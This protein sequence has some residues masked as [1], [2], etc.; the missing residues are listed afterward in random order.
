MNSES[1]KKTPM[2]IQYEKLK[3]EHMDCI[4]F[5][6]L[7]DFYEMF[8]KDAEIASEILGIVLT[9]RKNKSGSHKMCGVPFHSSENYINKLVEH[10]H[11]VA[12]AEQVSDPSQKGIV[13]RKVVNIVTPATNLSVKQS[14]AL[15]TIM[16]VEMLGNK[17]SMGFLIADINTLSLTKGRLWSL[18]ELDEVLDQHN[19]SEVVC[20]SDVSKEILQ[21]LN[22]KSILIKH[23]DKKSLERILLS[24]LENLNLEDQ[25][26]SLFAHIK[27]YI[28]MHLGQFVRSFQ[29]AVEYKSE[30]SFRLSYKTA[31]NLEV[32]Q[33]FDGSNKNSLFKHINFCQ[34]SMGSRKLMYNL[35]TPLSCKQAIE[36]R[37][38]KLQQFVDSNAGDK[39]TDILKEI[40]NIPRLVARIETHKATPADLVCLNSSLKNAIALANINEIKEIFGAKD[41]QGQL[42]D[43]L[44]KLDT[45]IE[46]DVKVILTKGYIFKEETT[47][48]LQGLRSIVENSHGLISNMLE[49]QKQATGIPNM[50]IKY[51]KV[52]GY[53]IE[54]SKGKTELVPEHYIRR[55]TLANAERYTTTDLQQF[56]QQV[57]S[58]EQDL[59]ALESEMF[60]ELLDFSKKYLSTI[61]ELSEYVAEIDLL[62]SHSECVGRMQFC[63]PEVTNENVFI[64]ENGFHPVIKNLLAYGEFIE[65][66][67][68]LDRKPFMVLTG[69]NMGG[70][71]TFLRQNAIILLLASIGCFVPASKA[72]LGVCDGIFTRV[73]ASDNLSKGQSTFMVEMEETAEILKKATPKSFVIIDELGR[74][75]SSLDGIAIASAVC[76][77]MNKQTKARTLFATH[78]FEIA[79]L[80]DQMKTAGNLCVSV[81]NGSDSKPVFLRKIIDGSIDR[82]YGVEVA[83]M[84]GLPDEI[85]VDSRE[86][87][88]CNEG[89]ENTGNGL[90]NKPALKTYDGKQLR[91]QRSLFANKEVAIRDQN[92]KHRGVA[93]YKLQSLLASIDLNSLTPIEAMVKLSEL[94]KFAKKNLK[95]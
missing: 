69:P 70:K 9:A 33:N 83:A 61:V 73:G 7:G 66:N 47:E 34:T 18:N 13:E 65:N 59:V 28:E 81:T 42:G 38:S 79:K 40:K 93:D 49:E 26:A 92:P 76:K 2:Q 51:N 36:Q 32:F 75:T 27:H 74:G 15:T 82:S 39:V 14:S 67:L 64:V 86:Y 84:A 46:T 50:K 71:S 31:V 44:E 52:F 94:Q 23:L 90:S 43:I 57:L 63:K 62:N 53:F 58:A 16:S 85:L 89:L 37:L 4:L 45:L 95:N 72:K 30:T 88:A 19:V 78:F 55:Q 41:Y 3:S 24:E 22:N 56:E 21:I 5:F 12:V 87:I 6:R 25:Q 8:D 80:V 54:V 10:G 68:E 60:M 91:N 77:F 48:K 29:Q 11:K 1:S 35:L 17:Q 20:Q